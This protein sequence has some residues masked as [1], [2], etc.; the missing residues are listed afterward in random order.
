MGEASEFGGFVVNTLATTNAT[1]RTANRGAIFDHRPGVCEGLSRTAAI[2]APLVS[3]VAIKVDG[4]VTQSAV[5][6][7][8][9]S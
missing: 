6:S 3:R 2:G 9:L 7:P 8:I 4:N 1:N 5:V